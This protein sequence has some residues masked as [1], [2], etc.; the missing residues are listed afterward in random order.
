M[1]VNVDTGLYNCFGCGASGNFSQ[2]TKKMEGM[3]DAPKSIPSNIIEEHHLILL[4]SKKGREIIIE[5]RGISLSVLEKYKIGFDSQRFWIPIQDDKGNYI[6]VRK[7]RYDKGTGPKMVGYDKGY[8]SISLFPKDTMDGNTVYIMEGEMDCLLAITI[9]LPAVTQTAGAMSWNNKFNSRFH[10]KN[11]VICYDNDDAGAKGSSMVAS[12]LQS[13][14]NS[15]KIVKLPVELEHEDFTDY[16]LKYNHT[17]DDFLSLINS[18]PDVLEAKKQVAAKL[19]E[20]SSDETEYEIDLIDAA[21]SE[22][23]NKIVNVPVQI[24]GKIVPAYILPKKVAMV[25]DGNKKACMT[26]PIFA[27]HGTVMI[28]MDMYSQDVIGM[29]GAPEQILNAKI[30]EAV[31]IPMKCS[32][33]TISV[34]ESFNIEVIIAINDIEKIYKKSDYTTSEVFYIGQGLPTNNKYML[35]GKVYPNPRTQQA[36]ILISEAKPTNENISG[37]GF[38]DED[39]EDLITFQT[40][41]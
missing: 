2:F 1:S 33:A 34:V 26:C 18:M 25:C 6:N 10:K 41:R 24:I 17:K 39:L 27:N 9:G 8:N 15:I 13:V 31:D 12:C 20:I 29:V 19:K 38:S 40:E 3:H 37:D 14:A 30:R 32:V 4:K 22:Y 23:V 28:D 35:T 36:T 7:Y 21:N 16:I 11:I 5:K